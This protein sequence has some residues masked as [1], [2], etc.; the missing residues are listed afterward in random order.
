MIWP[1]AWLSLFNTD[2][3]MLRTGSQY[4]HIVG[5]VAAQFLRLL[6]AVGGSAIALRLESVFLA[7]GIALAVFGLTVAL[8]IAS[9]SWSSR[10]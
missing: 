9:G 10:R 6:V 1:V 4:L 3:A 8:S 5:P 2:P 7:I